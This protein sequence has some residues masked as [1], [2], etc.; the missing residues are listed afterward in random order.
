MQHSKDSLFAAPL[1]GVVSPPPVPHVSGSQP[2]AREAAASARAAIDAVDA[3]SGAASTTVAVV[4]AAPSEGTELIAQLIG[5]VAQHATLA[6]ALRGPLKS[7]AER[8]YD[9]GARAELS[10][11]T[12]LVYACLQLNDGGLVEELAHKLYR[13][14]QVQAHAHAPCRPTLTAHAL[15]SAVL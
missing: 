2:R 15:R 1:F 5:S 8:C 13:D 6:E 14:H 7:Y 4:S 12:L 10:F 3:R 11:V 9:D